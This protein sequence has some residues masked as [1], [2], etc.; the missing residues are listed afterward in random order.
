MP[1]HIYSLTDNIGR[2]LARSTTEPNNPEGKRNYRI[3]SWLDKKHM[4][5]TEGI[6]LHTGISG[7]EL[8]TS[9]RRLKFAGVIKEDSTTTLNTV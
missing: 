4:D 6:A 5:T 7:G 3:I 1:L 9:L 2:P 8:G